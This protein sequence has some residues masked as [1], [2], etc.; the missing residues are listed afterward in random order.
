MRQSPVNGHRDRR[1]HVTTS[2]STP[3]KS[4]GTPENPLLELSPRIVGYFILPD[5]NSAIDVARMFA[6]DP[7]AGEKLME[8]PGRDG[9]VAET[10]TGGVP[11]ACDQLPEGTII[12]SP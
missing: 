4:K 5:S 6:R 3:K 12:L 1:G 9:V 7:K 11:D 8:D 2:D 10:I